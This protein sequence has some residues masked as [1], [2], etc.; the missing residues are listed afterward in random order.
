MTVRK[1]ILFGACGSTT[2]SDGVDVERLRA[3]RRRLASLT[4]DILLPGTTR[5]ELPDGAQG[6][7]AGLGRAR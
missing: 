5:E 7:Q 6:R 1:R 2:K 3:H 4:V